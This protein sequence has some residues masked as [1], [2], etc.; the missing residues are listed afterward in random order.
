MGKVTGAISARGTSGRRVLRQTAVAVFLGL[1]VGS[2][3]FLTPAQAQSYSFSSVSVEGN[4][5]VDAATIVS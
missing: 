3:P 1:A 4:E 2:A 5:R